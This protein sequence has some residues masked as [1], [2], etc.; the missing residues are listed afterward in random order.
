MIAKR[1]SQK[2]KRFFLLRKKSAQNGSFCMDGGMEPSSGGGAFLQPA[3]L[4]FPFLIRPMLW[5]HFRLA[6]R[7]NGFPRAGSKD[8]PHD[9]G[10]DPPWVFDEFSMMMAM[11]QDGEE[12]PFREALF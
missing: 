4:V 1:F 7:S 12:G 9:A 6:V 11:R 5:G 3:P 10:D 8:E 2:E